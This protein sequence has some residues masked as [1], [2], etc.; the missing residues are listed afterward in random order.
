MLIYWQDVKNLV[1]AFIP[2]PNLIGVITGVLSSLVASLVY[3]VFQK[4]VWH[5]DKESLEKGL[6]EVSIAITQ[7]NLEVA[8]I[9]QNFV[10]T[11]ASVQQEIAGA[12]KNYSDLVLSLQKAI[13]GPFTESVL[14]YHPRSSQRIAEILSI[15]TRKA[16]DKHW[17]RVVVTNAADR[18]LVTQIKKLTM[19]EQEAEILVWELEYQVSW[20]W[21]NDS[22]VTRHPLDDLEIMIVA[23]DD[24]V[25]DFKPADPESASK[26]YTEFFAKALNCVKCVV[27]NPQDGEKRLPENKISQLFRINSIK[28]IQGNNTLTLTENDLVDEKKPLPSGVYKRLEIPKEKAGNFTLEI[29]QTM[30]VVY[31]GVMSTPVLQGEDGALFGYLGYV[32]SD[33]VADSF[34]LSLS[35]PKEL[36]FNDLTYRT[37]VISDVSGCQYLR[38]P[39]RYNPE[40]ILDKKGIP[41]KFQPSNERQVSQIR[42]D[43]TLTHFHLLTLTWKASPVSHILGPIKNTTQ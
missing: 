18:Y 28:F 30:E 4:Q 24:A 22:K 13:G 43:E 12:D 19:G 14:G 9:R 33:I 35:H 8:N 10:D 15:E 11:M 39:L 17:S 25:R 38:E 21:R 7:L 29:G 41:Q 3:G 20:T 2:G 27:P 32:P 6:G 40:I 1:N 5:K 42:I 36:V 26:E 37:E 16:Y 34:K 31:E 23:P